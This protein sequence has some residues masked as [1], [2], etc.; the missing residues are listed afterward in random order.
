MPRMR[1][2]AVSITCCKSRDSDNNKC[3]RTRLTKKVKIRLQQVLMPPVDHKAIGKTS[4]SSRKNKCSNR[5]WSSN[6]P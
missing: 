3:A 4:V 1:R 5:A 2:S 6:F